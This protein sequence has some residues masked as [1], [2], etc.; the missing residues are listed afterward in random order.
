V[1]VTV[2]KKTAEDGAADV[3]DRTTGEERRVPLA[4]LGG[5]V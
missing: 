3:R 4:E 1:R 5:V 2:G